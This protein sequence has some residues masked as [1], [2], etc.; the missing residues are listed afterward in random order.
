[1]KAII[2]VATGSGLGGILRYGIQLMVQRLHSSPFPFG[3]FS[4][5]II[6]CLLIGIFFGL[7]EK[8]NLLNAEI[9]LFLIT[10][11]CGGFTTFSSFSIENIA[12]LR[13]GE[14]AYFFLYTIGSVALGLLTT[15]FGIYLI[16]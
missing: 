11:F 6:G 9:R 13:S 8:E 1:M 15:F 14:P 4:V 10:G 3:T 2:I 12:L 16:R 7:A 5:N